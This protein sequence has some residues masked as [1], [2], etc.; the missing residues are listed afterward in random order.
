MRHCSTDH[1]LLCLLIRPHRLQVKKEYSSLTNGEAIR[2][3]QC[4]LW[5]VGGG[6]GVGDEVKLRYAVE[7]EFGMETEIWCEI[8]MLREIGEGDGERMEGVGDTY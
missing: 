7:M 5:L 6:G 3:I 8:E 4:R 1:R 2:L